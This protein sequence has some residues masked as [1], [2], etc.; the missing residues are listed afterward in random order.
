[1]EDLIF[2][3]ILEFRLGI[4]EYSGWFSSTMSD[5]EDKKSAYDKILHETL[6]ERTG[7]NFKRNLG[8]APV[9]QAPERLSKE[10]AANLIFDNILKKREN[11]PAKQAPAQDSA[12]LSSELSLD[13]RPTEIS[14]TYSDILDSILWPED[15]SEDSP[16]DL[17]K[18]VAEKP[19]KEP[20]APDYQS[21]LHKT[22]ANRTGKAL[23]STGKKNQPVNPPR[24]Q[25]PMISQTFAAALDSVLD[26]EEE[27]PAKGKPP[28][29]GKGKSKAENDLLTQ[30]VYNQQ[31]DEILWPSEAKKKSDWD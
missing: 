17:Q 12:P 18:T 30:T 28:L 20:V 1:M 8:Q 19:S 31:L 26:F 6:L 11:L 2:K 5:S 14:E 3:E 27:R 9:P 21:I 13:Q 10:D 7:R 24:S 15:Q 16:P 25:Q 4:T 22:L 23:D 29:G